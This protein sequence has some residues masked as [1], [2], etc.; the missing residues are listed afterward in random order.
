MK[1]A[2]KL[3]T[4]IFVVTLLCSCLTNKVLPPSE[5]L[6]GAWNLVTLEDLNARLKFHYED[7]DN[8][9]PD[10]EPYDPVISLRVTYKTDGSGYSVAEFQRR[11]RFNHSFSYYFVSRNNYRSV[12]L[13]NQGR[14]DVVQETKIVSIDN[15]QHI[16]MLIGSYSDGKE[17]IFE[18]LENPL[19]LTF[20]RE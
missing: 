18:S 2:A 20:R 13:N 10:Q 4:S 7:K 12:T 15:N 14:V 5:S 9:V 19:A 6:V 11:E 17:E 1:I 3:T 8:V 16:Q